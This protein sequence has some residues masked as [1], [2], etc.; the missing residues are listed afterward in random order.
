MRRA[1]RHSTRLVADTVLGYLLLIAGVVMLLTPGPGIVA[2]VAGLAVLG[3]HYRWAQRV[4]G[5]VM[6]RIR[7][8]STVV[9]AR[10]VGRRTTRLAR[11]DTPTTEREAA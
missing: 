4:R 7:D 10:V 3:R 11:P 9:R 6:S 5:L 2:L 8:A 1:L